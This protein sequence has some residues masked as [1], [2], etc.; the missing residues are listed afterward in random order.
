MVLILLNSTYGPLYIRPEAIAS[1][2][3]IPEGL[4]EN[5]GDVEVTMVSGLRYFISMAD[6]ERAMPILLGETPQPPSLPQSVIDAFKAFAKA[7][8]PSTKREELKGD[9]IE[10]LD[11]IIFPHSEDAS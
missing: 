11:D 9:L 1:V 2:R 4:R 8:Y 7:D 10:I 3:E 5:R 6:W